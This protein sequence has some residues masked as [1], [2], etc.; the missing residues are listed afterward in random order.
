MIFAPTIWSGHRLHSIRNQD[1]HVTLQL[2]ILHTTLRSISRSFSH[3]SRHIQI[4][5]HTRNNSALRVIA[6]ARQRKINLTPCAELNKLHDSNRL[7]TCRVCFTQ[8]AKFL[9]FFVTA[10]HIPPKHG[11]KAVNRAPIPWCKFAGCANSRN[12]TYPQCNHADGQRRFIP[13]ASRAPVQP[14]WRLHCG[15]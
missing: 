4:H 6:I 14:T 13:C 11:E 1:C 8:P 5:T 9:R 10:Q 3:H 7:L 15:L 2:N 12:P